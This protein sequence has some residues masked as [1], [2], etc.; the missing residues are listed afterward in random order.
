MKNLKDNEKIKKLSEALR[1]NLKRRKTNCKK[2]NDEK[3]MKNKSIKL[4]MV[5]ILSG[6]LVSCG[7]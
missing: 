4:A 1:K 3:S 7:K 5:L 2:D 6:M